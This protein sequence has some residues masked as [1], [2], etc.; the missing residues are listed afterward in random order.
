MA[1]CPVH[2]V[3]CGPAFLLQAVATLR[4]ELLELRK[5]V[6]LNYIA[7]VKAAKKRNRHLRGACGQEQV[8]SLRAIQVLSQ[9]YFFT[10][11]KLAAL[12][13][14]AEILAKVRC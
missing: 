4:A 3:L 10:S 5:F 14:Q 11:P 7:V 2:C 8:A 1:H 13:T 6:V 9:Q 12:S